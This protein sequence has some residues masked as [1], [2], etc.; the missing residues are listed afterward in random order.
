M[1]PTHPMT[2]D[3]QYKIYNLLVTR[4]GVH[5]PTKEL[6]EIVA[7]CRGDAPTPPPLTPSEK[8]S[9]YRELYYSNKT[10]MDSIEAKIEELMK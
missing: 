4:H 3:P 1:D 9:W 5:P 8:L 10:K 2:E 6:D 7:I